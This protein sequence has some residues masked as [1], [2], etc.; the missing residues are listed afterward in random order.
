[1]HC[2][3][4]DLGSELRK[5]VEGILRRAPVITVAPV[6]AKLGKI[7]R[8]SAVLPVCIVIGRI[9]DDGIGNAARY[10]V[11]PG[12]GNVEAERFFHHGSC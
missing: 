6:I 12:L 1:M 11:E 8:V 4:F 5:G 10:P 2:D 7:M 9:T 3:A